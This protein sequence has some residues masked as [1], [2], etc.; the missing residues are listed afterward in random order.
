MRISAS[1]LR[2]LRIFLRQMKRIRKTCSIIK[3]IVMNYTSLSGVGGRKEV[4]K[5]GFSHEVSSKGER[6]IGLKASYDGKEAKTNEEAF[7][8]D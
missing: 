7:E 8:T 1:H 4:T 2:L 6:S 5:G 3:R